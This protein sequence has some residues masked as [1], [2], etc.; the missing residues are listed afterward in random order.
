MTGWAG[1]CAIPK[2]GAVPGPMMYYRGSGYWRGSR[3]AVF[4]TPHLTLCSV[5]QYS[6]SSFLPLARGCLT[7]ERD[8]RVSAPR[9]PDCQGSDKKWPKCALFMKGCEKWGQDVAIKAGDR[10]MATPRTPHDCLQ[11]SWLPCSPLSVPDLMLGSW[12]FGMRLQPLM[13]HD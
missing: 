5:L 10:E 13:N 9:H 4:S 3:F 2:S 8:Q 7:S 1:F 6:C 12:F 11:K